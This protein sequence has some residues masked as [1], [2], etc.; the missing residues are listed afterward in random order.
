MKRT[1]AQ[2]EANVIP[3]K[4]VEAVFRSLWVV[5]LPVIL[6]P[7]LV[8]ALT[9]SP[10]VYQSNATAWVARPEGIDS[11][12][13]AQ[14]ESIYRSPAE[15]QVQVFNDLLATSSF[16]T[17][18]AI[19]AK[20]IPAAPGEDLL[21]VATDYVWRNVSVYTLGTNLIGIRAKGATPEDAYRIANAVIRQYELRS[22][23]R[24]RPPGR[25]CHRILHRAADSRPG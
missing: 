12:A 25:D 5:L 10:M 6:V 20:L 13:L 21:A 14:S 19:D 23:R 9:E 3:R 17:D 18:I 16:R 22:G 15:N 4:L 11:G 2:V 8:I 24:N 1:T 7:V